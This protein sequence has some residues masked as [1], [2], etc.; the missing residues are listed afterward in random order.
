MIYFE[1][2]LFCIQTSLIYWP[3]PKKTKEQITFL[4]SKHVIVLTFVA[5]YTFILIKEFS[6]M[7]KNELPDIQK[8]KK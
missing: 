7:G 6:G 3:S 5:I 2:Y 8:N 1:V 4:I